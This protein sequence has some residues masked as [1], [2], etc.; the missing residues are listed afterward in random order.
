MVLLYIVI[1]LFLKVQYILPLIINKMKRKEVVYNVTILSL[2]LLIN[3]PYW[4][5]HAFV[6]PSEG[7]IAPFLLPSSIHK[8]VDQ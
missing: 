1:L 3:L 6:L 8:P 5:W 4:L 2:I 7:L